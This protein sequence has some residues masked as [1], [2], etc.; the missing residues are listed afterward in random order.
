MLEGPEREAKAQRHFGILASGAAP[1]RALAGGLHFQGASGSFH[2]R[3]ER[4]EEKAQGGPPKA[5]S[6]ASAL[7]RRVLIL[8]SKLP[9]GAAPPRAPAA[10]LGHFGAGFLATYYCFLV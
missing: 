8:G 4:Q 3:R 5:V 10:G 7:A 9:R 6:G 2:G 1:P